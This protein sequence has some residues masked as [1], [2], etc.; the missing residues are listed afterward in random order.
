MNRDVWWKFIFNWG[1]L[2]GFHLG[3]LTIILLL[4]LLVQGCSFLNQRQGQPTARIAT[5]FPTVVNPLA[6]PEPAE[7]SAAIRPDLP[8]I[9]ASLTRYTIRLDI[10]DT[11]Q[12]FTG[13]THID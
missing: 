9:P 2:R 3:W 12:G 7:Q 6:S 5:T 11:G 13:F 1:L 4:L 8:P 10:D